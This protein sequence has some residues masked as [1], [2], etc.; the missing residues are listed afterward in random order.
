M[1]VIRGYNICGGQGEEEWEWNGM[2]WPRVFLAK[3]WMALLVR[4]DR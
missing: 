2:E 3:L 1:A 4:H